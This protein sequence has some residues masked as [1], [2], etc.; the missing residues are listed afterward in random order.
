MASPQEQLSYPQTAM[1]FI[2]GG[3][4]CS[5]AVTLGRLYADAITSDSA[6]VVVPGVSHGIPSDAAGAQAVF[7]LLSTQCVMRH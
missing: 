3:I 6:I 7:D 4:D 5:E 1:R 2:Y